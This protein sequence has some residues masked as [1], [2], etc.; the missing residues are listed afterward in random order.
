MGIALAGD[1]ECGRLSW[2]A[3][4]CGRGATGKATNSGI[5]ALTVLGRPRRRRRSAQTALFARGL[6]E[7]LHS[8]PRLDPRA[9][10]K[11]MGWWGD[12]GGP[13][14]KGIVQYS[15]WSRSR[16]SWWLSLIDV[17]PLSKHDTPFKHDTPCPLRSCALR[18][19]AC[20][21]HWV[22]LRRHEHQCSTANCVSRPSGYRLCP[23]HRISP[24]R[25]ITRRPLSTLSPQPHTPLLIPSAPE[26]TQHH[27]PFAPAALSPFKQKAMRG[28]FQGYLFNGFRRIMAQVP[29]FALPFAAGEWCRCVADSYPHGFP[30][31]RGS[32][33]H[34]VPSHNAGARLARSVENCLCRDECALKNEPLLI[35]SGYSVYVWGNTK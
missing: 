10:S 25:L 16:G 31:W 19:C 5:L 2:R 7:E 35:C 22:L 6:A 1:R 26:P 4:R 21:L 3:E 11:Q 24:C 27:D 13:R 33:D 30:L 28:V 9:D 20:P 17:S 32:W 15:A 29:Y 14:Q 23:P 12:M 18:S 34:M 8:E